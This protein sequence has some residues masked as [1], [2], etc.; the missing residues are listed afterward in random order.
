M[1]CAW[2]DLQRNC[3]PWWGHC[4]ICSAPWLWLSSCLHLKIFTNFRGPLDHRAG[5]RQ[6]LLNSQCYNQKSVTCTHL[7]LACFLSCTC[8]SISSYVSQER[9]HLM[10]VF[11]FWWG[12]G[13]VSRKHCVKITQQWIRRL[14]FQTCW[15]HQLAV[16]PWER[17]LGQVT[18]LQINKLNS[19]N[20][21]SYSFNLQ[22]VF[23]REDLVF[24][25]F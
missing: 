24:F 8:S 23:F 25:C 22:S 2:L 12:W 17:H 6:E 20:K 19:I 16:W 7:V 9:I 3:S 11:F 18:H 14:G 1:Q 5:G 10:R 21:A 4:F 15:C 13:L